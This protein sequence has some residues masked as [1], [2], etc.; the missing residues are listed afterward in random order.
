MRVCCLR[1]S[2][3]VEVS[4]HSPGNVTCRAGKTVSRAVNEY[5]H[6]VAG[7]AALVFDLSE[8]IPVNKL[9]R[10]KEQE[11]KTCSRSCKTCSRVTGIGLSWEV[12]SQLIDSEPFI[13]CERPDN[14]PVTYITESKL[15]NSAPGVITS[16]G[17]RGK[18]C[19]LK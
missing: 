13:T 12:A 15:L 1:F 7:R 8:S 16:I 3:A 4:A 9:K 19:A 17:S 10:N 6:C 5:F 2:I 11:C 14:F 18:A